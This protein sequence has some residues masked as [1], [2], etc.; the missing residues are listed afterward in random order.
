MQAAHEAGVRWVL[1]L[2]SDGQHLVS[3]AE[4][5]LQPV[6]EAEPGPMLVLGRRAGMD[7]PKVPWTSRW[8]RRWSNFWVWMAGG[9]WVSDSQ[10]GFR[11]YPVPETLQL[12]SRSTRFQF[13]MEVLVDAHRAG[14]PIRSADVS[15]EYAPPGGRISHMDPWK[16]FLRNTV[17]IVRLMLKRLMPRPALPAKVDTHAP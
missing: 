7:G 3:E 17:V 5:L 13:E 16:D 1:T 11:L 4:R 6:L 15:V 10:S 2:D 12:P 14:I 9:S 8:G